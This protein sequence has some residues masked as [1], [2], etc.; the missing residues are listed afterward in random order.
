[1]DVFVALLAH[2]KT[3]F[4][5]AEEGGA[6]VSKLIEFTVEITNRECAFRRSLDLVQ[7]V[8]A[9]LNR[10]P[11]ALSVK[12]LQFSD[13]RIQ[14]RSKSVHFV[15]G[16]RISPFLILILPWVPS[17]KK[18]KSRASHAPNRGNLGSLFSVKKAPPPGV[19]NQTFSSK[20]SSIDRPSARPEHSQCC[21]H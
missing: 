10:D 6:S 13:S 11:G 1:M 5:N 2:S 16:H 3:S 19:V 15:L 7:L 4:L 18:P 8:G 20:E 9:S 21:A 17:K 14:D 12:V